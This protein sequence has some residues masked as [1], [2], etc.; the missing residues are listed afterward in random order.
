MQFTFTVQTDVKLGFDVPK[1]PEEVNSLCNAVL[2]YFGLLNGVVCYAE[3]IEFE[4][5]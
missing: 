1:V 3:F 4:E 5:V 2:C